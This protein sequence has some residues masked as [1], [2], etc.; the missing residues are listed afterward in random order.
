ME[1]TNPAPMRPCSRCGGRAWQRWSGG[2]PVGGWVCAVCRPAEDAITMAKAHALH[3][4]IAAETAA[5][6][7]Q[8]HKT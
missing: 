4:Q 2:D 1:K 7:R 3:A 8:S 5:Y 6:R